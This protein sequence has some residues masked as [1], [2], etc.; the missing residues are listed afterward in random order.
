MAIPGRTDANV[1]V[2]AY[3]VN[4]APEKKVAR[5]ALVVYPSAMPPT[6]TPVAAGFSLLLLV[7]LPALAA[8][9][10]RR[11]VDLRAAATHRR[12]LYLS[13]ALS[14]LFIATLTLG[15]ATWQGVPARALRWTVETPGAAIV[16]GLFVAVA[17]LALTWVTTMA[18]RLGGLEESPVAMLLMPRDTPEKI[19]FLLLSGV[20]AVCEEYAFRGFGLWALS[21]WTG[22]P[23][24]AAILVSLSFGLAHGYQHLAGILRAGL[25]GLL[26]AASTIWTGS[27]FP[28]IVGHFWINAAVGLGGWRYL[29][30]DPAEAPAVDEHD[31][32]SHEARVQDRDKEER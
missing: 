10:A 14:L 30:E 32:S 4:G 3:G 28:A 19:G 31:P 7:G 5:T 23:W 18:A 16:W 27:L 8:L 12:T 21:E 29:L 9:D 20:A 26:L 11:G 25:L 13:V 6:L 17:G 22:V 1:R 24:L 15:V 2:R